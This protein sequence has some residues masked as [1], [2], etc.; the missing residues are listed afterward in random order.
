MERINGGPFAGLTKRKIE[1]F[2]IKFYI[3][4][5]AGIIIP[6]TRDF[7]IMLTPLTLLLCFAALLAFHKSK[8]NLKTI[9]VFFIICIAGFFIEVA[10]VKTGMVFGDY[11][12]GKTLGVKVFETPLMIGINWAM[13]IY[14]SASL[15]STLSVTPLI[16]IVIASLLMLIYD[17]VLEQIA[18]LLDMWH[19]QGSVIPARNYASWFIISLLLHTLFYLTGIKNSTIARVIYICQISFFVL[20]IIFFRFIA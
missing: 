5:L 8:L 20:L 18:P 17:V 15:V 10:G 4:G 7:F 9:L 19:W 2:F 11:A 13:L 16:R 1:H 14:I 12:Y 3:I 6:F